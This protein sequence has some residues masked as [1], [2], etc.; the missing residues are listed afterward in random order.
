[1]GQHEEIINIM[2]RNVGIIDISVDDLDLSDGYGYWTD[3]LSVEQ[4]VI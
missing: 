4:I 3:E 2:M 1:L